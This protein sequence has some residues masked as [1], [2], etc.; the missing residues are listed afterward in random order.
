MVTCVGIAFV[1]RLLPALLLPSGAAFDIASSAIVGSLLR[2]S[3]DV[4]PAPLAEGRH[5]Y[6][7]L[8]LFID[9]LAHRLATDYRLPFP[10]LVK[11]VPVP[12]DVLLTLLI[13]RVSSRRPLETCATI[14]VLSSVHP[15]AVSVCAYH[16]QF[17]AEPLLAAVLAA[18]AI[19]SGR[20]F[21]AG[22]LLGVAIALKPWP[23]L[24]VPVFIGCVPQWRQRGTLLI[25]SRLAPLACVA[26][27]RSMI[28]G[29]WVPV[30]ATVVS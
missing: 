27:Y 11:V 20:V 15:G 5:P 2:L 23:A 19:A 25:A 12:A 4:Y 7:P 6:F 18:L 29:S 13:T 8:Q 26:L 28:P 9:A 16:G 14:A 17:D 3:H 24:F 1:A 10:V 21:L 22:L 30:V